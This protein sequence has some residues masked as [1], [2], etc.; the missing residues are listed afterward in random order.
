[1][2]NLLI[3]SFLFLFITSCK[4][5]EKLKVIEKNTVNITVNLSEAS[6]KYK[7]FKPQFD[8]SN[9]MF[10]EIIDNNSFKSSFKIT[11]PNIYS[12]QNITNL[13]VE[14]GNEYRIKEVDSSIIIAGKDSIGQHFLNTTKI[15]NVYWE[16]SE[17]FFYEFPNFKERFDALDKHLSADFKTLDSLYKNKHVSKPF[18]ENVK[19]IFET[20]KIITKQ[21]IIANDYYRT[22]YPK[23]DPEYLE[24]TPDTTIELW[25]NLFKEH[26]V[27]DPYLLKNEYWYY[28]AESFVLN[29]SGAILQNTY[30][31][32]DDEKYFTK[33]IELSKTVLKDDV[34]E[35]FIACFIFEKTQY[36]EFQANL[37]TAYENFTKDY[38]NSKYTQ[39]LT[40]E[41]DLI[42]EYQHKIKGD[43]NKNITFVNNGENINTLKDL[44]TL[45]KGKNLYIDVW[46]TWCGP[47][48]D[49]F[50][51]SKKLKKFLKKHDIQLLYLSNDQER[52]KKKWPEMIKYYNLEGEHIRNNDKLYEDLGKEY[53]EEYM[54][55][56]WYIIVNKKGEIVVRHAKRPSDK[57]ELYKQLQETLKLVN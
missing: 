18:Y 35:Y 34:L 28:Y 12:I 6:P 3:I 20:Y 29:Y 24:K 21:S 14:P 16:H 33:C 44:I 26:P 19:N 5:D 4:K 32:F 38:P 11:T 55:I 17:Y 23:T 45:Y 40:S 57:E 15:F 27:T 48:K 53:H 30:I 46:A 1:M 10:G 7:I 36:K 54:A 25:A 51:H 41:I 42:K 47:C 50:K 2:K 22:T 8:K 43:F 13:Y 49:E 56:P 52:S 9:W 39:Y 37:V 31:H